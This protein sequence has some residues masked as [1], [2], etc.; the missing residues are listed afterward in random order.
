[1]ALVIDN[2]VGFET[3][4]E[5]E[6]SSSNGSPTIISTGQRTG[7]YAMRLNGTDSIRIPIFSTIVV[8]SDL[9]IGFGVNFGDTTPASSADF[10]V[11]SASGATVSPRL[12]LETDGKVTISFSAGSATSVGAPFIDA[13]DHFVE[14][15]V[16][17]DNTGGSAELFVDGSPVV[18]ISGL[19]TFGN[20]PNEVRFD[21]SSDRGDM[22][23]DDVYIQVDTAGGSS[24]SD[25][26]GDAE[27]FGYQHSV[28]GAVADAGLNGTAQTNLSSGGWED[29]VD[30]S[31][32]T[33]AAM[34][35]SPHYGTVDFDG[36]NG[37]AN[38][39]GDSNIKAIKALTRLNRD[40]GG[41]TTHYIGLGNSS[42]GN[43][44]GLYDD[45]THWGPITTTITWYSIVSETDL[46]SASQDIRMGFG[47]GGAQN[48]NCYDSWAMLL[49]VPS[50]G[51]VTIPIFDHHYRMM[52]A[53]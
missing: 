46:P 33:A 53:A 11:L 47:T 19:D 48:I 26:L 39:D 3:G 5:E 18:S 49:H 20:V 35:S 51:G 40:G 1:M 21:A 14:L 25:R 2:Y 7:A 27:V 15:Y 41:G 24:A 12:Q 50:V 43:N 10:F 37:D 31:D 23:I 45:N 28:T 36:P 38:I 44:A 42:Q 17:L 16:R 8:G 22:D 13:T 29:T 32:G 52:R 30:G 6:L 9:I 4:G 34:D